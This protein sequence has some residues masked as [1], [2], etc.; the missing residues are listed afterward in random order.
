MDLKV[1]SSYEFKKPKYRVFPLATPIDLIDLERNA[2]AKIKILSL[3]NTNDETTGKF[4]ILKIYTEMEKDVL[5][6][7]WLENQ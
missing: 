2:I 5:S 7:Y 4:E 6:N 1:G 3:T